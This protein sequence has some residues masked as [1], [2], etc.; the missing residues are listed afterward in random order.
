MPVVT[1]VWQPP[2][3]GEARTVTLSVAN[4]DQLSK[5]GRTSELL[6]GAPRASGSRRSSSDGEDINYATLEHAGRPHRGKVSPDEAAFVRENLAAV[7]E[8]LAREGH[9]LIDPT[10]KEHKERYGF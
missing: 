5:R 9:R 1:V 2:G 7:N 10:N 4:F 3:D 6:E 8:R